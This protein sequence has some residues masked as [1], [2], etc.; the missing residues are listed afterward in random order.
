MTVSVLAVNV[1]CTIMRALALKSFDP[2]CF[3]KLTEKSNKHLAGKVAF[4]N[5]AMP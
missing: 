3:E 2:G 4:T 1:E 5:K